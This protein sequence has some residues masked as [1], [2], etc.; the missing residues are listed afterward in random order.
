MKKALCVVALFALVA[1][2]TADI[3][4]FV[5]PKSAGYGLVNPA[6]MYIPTLSTVTPTGENTN[7]YDYYSGAGPFV[8]GTV[9]P[10]A[11]PSGT[12][13]APILDAGGEYYIWIQFQ[14]IAKA[15]TCGVNGLTISITG[16]AL[17]D[18]AYYVANEKNNGGSKRWDGTV[19]AG[20]PEFKTNPQSLVAVTAAGVDKLNADTAGSPA[21]LM[22]WQ[23]G[24]TTAPRT[25]IALLGAVKVPV[26]QYQIQIT[27][28]GFKDNQTPIGAAGVFGTP[29]PASMLLLG[30]AGLLIRRR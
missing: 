1:S 2:A 20:A 19:T 5:T 15:T 21:L 17:T 30:L 24:L 7:G 12:A 6:N 4:V 26:G 23:E 9:P 27:N 8:L 14:S 25:S 10:V 18:V 28:I 29:E 13:V 11:A 16:G 22:K 3:R